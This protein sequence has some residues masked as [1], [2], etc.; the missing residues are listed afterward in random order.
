MVKLPL[1]GPW[2]VQGL[3]AWPNSHTSIVQFY[4]RQLATDELQKVSVANI[5]RGGGGR[6]HSTGVTMVLLTQQVN[7]SASEIYLEEF[8]LAQRSDEQ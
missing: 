6:L 7:L 3:R 1:A 4:N 2:S 8:F 5:Q